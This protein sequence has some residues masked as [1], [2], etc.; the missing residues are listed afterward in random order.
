MGIALPEICV[1][2]REGKE[3]KG[4][5]VPGCCGCP[6]SGAH[7]A[8]LVAQAKTQPECWYGCPICKKPWAG[9]AQL[10]V[11]QTHWKILRRRPE[12]DRDR[13]AAAVRL[14][15][16]LAACGQKD[17]AVRI[18]S[19]ALNTCREALAISDPL[20]TVVLGALGRLLLERGDLNAALPLLEDTVDG[21]R[22]TLGSEH[23]STLA[24]LSSLGALHMQL[25]DFER[26][27]PLLQ[28]AL[29][30]QR[31]VLGSDSTAT[32]N[33]LMNLA[34]VHGIMEEHGAAVPLLEEAHEA[35]K[36]V[37][38][39]SSPRTLSCEATLNMARLKL[40]KQSASTT[41]MSS[42]RKFM[43]G[44]SSSSRSNAQLG[45]Q[46]KPPLAAAQQYQS[47]LIHCGYLTCAWGMKRP[48]ITMHD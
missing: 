48:I 42:K 11:A 16:A 33:S 35:L 20:T 25:K 37:A 34:S 3:R 24:S 13:L 15:G 14:G 39:D 31:R 17:E 1:V 36:K 30:A 9:E 28:E 43:V 22:Q 23:P 47:L 4:N 19:K 5:V 7:V 18:C 45:P 26:A 8:C 32:L 27:K 21:R 29:A 2:C 41:C 12:E 44:S 46:A 38:G 40:A 10:G 6:Q